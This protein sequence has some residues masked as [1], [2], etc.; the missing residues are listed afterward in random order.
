SITR[1]SNTASFGGLRLLDGT[2]DYT[3]SGLVSSAITTAKI[4]GA[5]FPNGS[6]N[7]QVSVD[8]I[9]SAQTGAIFYN[10]GTT[11]PG[12]VLSAMTIEVRGNKGVQTVSLTSGE[13]LAQVVTA[14]NT[15]TG[16]TGVTASLI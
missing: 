3:L 7:I 4:T 16:M 9:A 6:N 15:M 12:Q 13:T 5:T 8:V 11:P 2:L 1:I 14:I 10:G